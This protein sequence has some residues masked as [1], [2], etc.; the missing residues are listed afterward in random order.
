MTAIGSRYRGTINYQRV[1]AELITAARYRGTTT[2]QAIAIILG[3]PLRGS[4]MGREVGQVL[5]EISED[6]HN[7]G[8]PMLSAVAVNAAGRP[9]PGFSALAEVLEKLDN[10]A[11]KDEK[12]QFWESERD[13]VHKLWGY[14]FST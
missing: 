5:G 7:A 12:A 1:T 13:E 6:E 9:G 8:R 14:S 3:L 4:H 2:Y 10:D 11:S